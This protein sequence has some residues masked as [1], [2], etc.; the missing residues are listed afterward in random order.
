MDLNFR[1]HLYLTNPSQKPEGPYRL[2]ILMPLPQG[3]RVGHTEM[4]EPK[5]SSQQREVKI[6]FVQ[7][8]N[9]VD[10]SLF[11]TQFVFTAKTVNGERQECE[12]HVVSIPSIP[13]SAQKDKVLN[14]GGTTIDHEDAD[15]KPFEP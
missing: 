7:D 5:T 15:D 14:T 13:L 1:P 3:Y 9:Q 8:A 11:S 6:H 12:I 2:S 4:I 10:E